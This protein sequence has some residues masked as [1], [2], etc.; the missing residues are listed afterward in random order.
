MQA[1]THTN[2][3]PPQSYH[4]LGEVELVTHILDL[5]SVPSPVA[6]VTELPMLFFKLLTID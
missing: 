2:E 6:A 1:I 3:E 4:L 5:D